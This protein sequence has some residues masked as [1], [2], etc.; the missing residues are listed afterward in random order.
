MVDLFTVDPTDHLIQVVV[1]HLRSD[2]ILPGDYIVVHPQSTAVRGSLA[3][4]SV[5]GVGELK[6]H[7]DG[8]RVLGVAVKVMGRRGATLPAERTGR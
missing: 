3:L 7:E 4:V 2:G 1:D 8:D 5:G 6:H